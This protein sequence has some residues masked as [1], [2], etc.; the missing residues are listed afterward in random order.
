[1]EYVTE[2]AG[3]VK[4]KELSKLIGKVMPKMRETMMEAAKAA[5]AVLSEEQRERG[6]HP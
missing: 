1:V 4:D 5:A 2:H 3:K 6:R